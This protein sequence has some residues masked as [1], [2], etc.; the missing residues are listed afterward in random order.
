MS[1]I[2]R[3]DPC[4]CGSGRKSKRCCLNGSSAGRFRVIHLQA[5][6]QELKLAP[7]T[8]ETKEPDIF[9]QEQHR[10]FGELFD[11]HYRRWL[12]TPLPELG[13]RTPRHA[14]RLKTVRPKLIALL[15]KMERSWQRARRAGEFAY[16]L[17]WVWAELGL[18]RE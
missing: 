13:D 7:K 4:P 15:K 6:K 12:D 14:A 3:D 8:S 5:I 10:L 17:T 1:V 16:D 2:G 9:I 11:R 18:K